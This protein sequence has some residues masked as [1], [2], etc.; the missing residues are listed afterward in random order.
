MRQ[1]PFTRLPKW[2]NPRR[3]E[4]PTV[5]DSHTVDLPGMTFIWRTKRGV[6]WHPWERVVISVT[7]WCCWVLIVATMLTILVWA[8]R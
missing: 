5:Q 2:A 8:T 1:L 7:M 3:A 4:D 6:L